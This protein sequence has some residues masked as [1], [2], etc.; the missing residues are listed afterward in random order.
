MTARSLRSAA[1]AL[2]LTLLGG[3]GALGWLALSAGIATADDGGQQGLLGPVTSVVESVAEPVRSTVRDAAAPLESAVTTAA[4]A[5]IIASTVQAV[6][7]PAV[8]QPV[9]DAVDPLVSPVLDPVVDPV[10][11]QV[12]NPV[13]VAVLPP[14]QEVTAPAEPIVDVVLPIL[15]PILPQED[16]AAGVPDLIGEGALVPEPGPADVLVTVLPGEVPADSAVATTAPAGLEPGSDPPAAD[17]PPARTA[18]LVPWRDAAYFDA[19]NA[20]AATAGS[21][22]PGPWPG[23]EP[24]VLPSAPSSTGSASPGSASGGAGVADTPSGFIFTPCTET[25]PGAGYSAALPEGP[26]FE[27]GSTPD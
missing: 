18:T 21:E 27:P 19:P 12:V 14:L 13:L 24:N 4:Q 3:F 11:S 20:A 26:A 16:P 25:S 23:L 2:R 5:P 17:T 15:D 1:K 9:L 10:V 22:A 6:D 8:V 7:A